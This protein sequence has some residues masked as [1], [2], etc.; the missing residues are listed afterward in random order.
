MKLA[1]RAKARALKVGMGHFDNETVKRRV[2]L[3]EA[4]ED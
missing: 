2:K 4:F 3:F 1:T